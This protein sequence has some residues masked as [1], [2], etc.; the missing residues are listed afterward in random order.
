MSAPNRATLWG[1]ILVDELAAGGLEAV[2]LAPGSRSTPLTVAFAEHPDIDVYSHLDERSAAYFA[3]GRARRTGEPTALV[4]TSG[5]AAANFHPAVM[6]ADQARVPLLV[7]TADRPSELRDSGANQTVDQVKLYG[8]AVRWDAELPDPEPDERKVRSLRTTAARALSETTGIPPGPVHLN[9]PFRK[10]LEPLEVPGDVP[11]SF[12]ETVA[13]RGRDGPF[14]ETTGG[15]QTLAADDHRR[16][17][18]ALEAA[19]RPLIVAGPA[20]PTALADLEPAAVTDLADRLGAPI[21]ADPLSGL[22]FGPHVEREDETESDGEGGD[23]N[24]NGESRSIYGGYDTYVEELPP[25]DAVL[26]FGA[27]PTSKPLRH[28]LRDADA[29]QFL[30][31]PAGAWR[32][33]TFT[34]TDL[35]AAEPGAVVDGLLEALGD[36]DSDPGADRTDAEWQAQFDAA[37]RRHWEIRDEALSPDALESEPF[38]GAILASVLS[39]APDPA[40]VFVSNSMPIRDTDR[41]ARPRAA[42]LT[43]LANRGAS[44]IDGIVST[45]LGAGSAADEP[46]VLATGDLS[47]Y[48]DSNGLLAVDR[49][50]VDATIVLLDNDGGGIFHK[51]PI[52][53]FDPPFT[54]QFKTPHGLEF[55]DLADVY[56]IEFERVT[57]ANFAAAYRR[58]LEA[59]GTQLIAI[60]FDSEANHRRRDAL[61]ERVQTAVASDLGTAGDGA[62]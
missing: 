46:L 35:L 1:R 51:L 47:L 21:L 25:P 28:W 15:T 7:L 5:T 56:D 29:R 49:C 50:D 52:E 30:V 42:D 10:P 43:V 26:R 11:D 55:E 16:L 48:H 38:E 6:E 14:V 37:E 62:D 24:R 20:D 2:C 22:R 4:C 57:P 9:C 53:A 12:A 8:D 3:L 36:A 54:D 60:E 31:D 18:G 13:G 33:A 39:N 34:A 32:E 40:T 58:S 59:A 17:L 19:D 27:S 23:G 41:F 61:A 45:A 44:G